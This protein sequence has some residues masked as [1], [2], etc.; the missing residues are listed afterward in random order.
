[1]RC[2]FADAR[3]FISDP[4]FDDEYEARL[5]RLLSKEYAASRA[6]LVSREKRSTL[7]EAGNPLDSCDTIYLC[8]VDRFGNGCSF[9]Q[10]NYAGFGT[11]LIPEGCG[12]TLQNR[13]SG[14]SLDPKHNNCLAPNKRP[15]HT[16]IPGMMTKG[17][18][19]YGVFGVMGGYMQPQGHLQVVSNIIDFGMD[20]QAALDS[21]RVCLCGV[22]HREGPQQQPV[23]HVEERIQDIQGLRAK[24][25]KVKVVRGL[26]RTEFG[27]G[28]MILRNP[29]TG[30]LSGGADPRSDGCCIPV[31]I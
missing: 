29:T 20:A 16:I 27:R 26:R 22:Q 3:E 5:K 30:I 13:G 28:H 18:E 21:H 24:G 19:L 2:A 4:T 8:A 12:F 7:I 31:V 10:S 23:L 6:T 11:G 14:F 9:I 25:H 1:M 17:K 15:Y